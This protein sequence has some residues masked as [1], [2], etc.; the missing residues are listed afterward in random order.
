[1]RDIMGRYKK[2]S[3]LGTQNFNEADAEKKLMEQYEQ[4]YEFN[5]QEVVLPDYDII[6]SQL[7]SKI[8]SMVTKMQDDKDGGQECDWWIAV[9]GTEG[10][11]KTTLTSGMLKYYC[12]KTGKDFVGLLKS[13][14]VF[15]DFEILRM[16]SK[17]DIDGK[18]NYIWADEGANVFFSRDS[19]SLAR[20]YAAKFA[21]S[22]RDL[23]PFV[24]ICSVE[25][26]QLDTIIR[27]HRVKVLIRI[28][29]HGVYHYYNY[30][31]LIRLMAKNKG[32]RDQEF[33]WAA[34][35]P[36]F[37]GSFRKSMEMKKLADM[38]KRNYRARLQFEAKQ[39]YT[40]Q[41]RKK[42]FKIENTKNHSKYK[43]GKS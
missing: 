16:I 30:D 25:M 8:D 36:E 12:E 18:F 28:E 6:D 20:K 38:L 34:V 17:M 24:T 13:Q 27:N 2:F 22:I 9:I 32:L 11:G 1:M 37:V 41:L 21:N 31:R 4:L 43:W 40:I 10:S 35:E 23:R 15:D 7:K 3:P 29:K 42:L 5:P 39:D 14:V 33:N 19:T 26:K